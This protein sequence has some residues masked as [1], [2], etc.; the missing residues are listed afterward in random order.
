MI[1]VMSDYIII[2]N[3]PTNLLKITHTS[4]IP[5]PKNTAIPDNS[6]A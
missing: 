6:Y 1:V 3:S 2:Y 4:A 5:S